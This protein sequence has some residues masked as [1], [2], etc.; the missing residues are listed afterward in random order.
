MGDVTELAVQV[1]LKADGTGLVGQLRLSQDAL[2]QLGATAQATGAQA[3]SLEA[4]TAA[5][6]A[7]A[8]AMAADLRQAQAAAGAMADE[9]RQVRTVAADLA[10]RVDVLESRLRQSNRT[11]VEGA[12]SAERHAFGIRNLGQQFGDLGLSIAGGISPARA[13]G[14]QAGQM[15]YAMSEMGGRAGKVGAFLTG[16]WGIALTVGAAVLA[17]LVE[18]LLKGGEAA[19]AMELGSSGLA[20]AQGALGDIFDLTTGKLKK[21]NSELAA[22]NELLRVNARLTAINLRTEAAQ[23][24][25][26]SRAA[27]AK[28]GTISTRG[29]LQGFG[30]GSARG[31]IAGLIG[32]VAG[33]EQGRFNA[34]NLNRVVADL[35]AGRT[36]PESV[37]RAAERLDFTGVGVDRDTFMAAIR[38][39]VSSAAK[40]EIADLTDQ[41]LNGGALPGGLR[42]EGRTKKPAKPASTAAR[43]EFGRDAADRLAAIT[44]Q[45]DATPEAVRKTNAEVRKLDDLIDD[46]RRKK[47]PNFAELIASAE[48]AKTVVR[49]GLIDGIAAAFDRPRTLADQAAAAFAE[50]DAVAADLERRR[51]PDL[52]RLL[53]QVDQ[54]RDRVRDGL[55][56]P[57]AEYVEAQAQSLQIGQALAAGDADRADALRAIFQLQRQM[58]PLTDEQRAAVLATTQALS[59]QERVV[60]RLARRQQNYL[61]ALGDMRSLLV[62]TIYEGPDAIAQLPKRLIDVFRRFAA[63]RLVEEWF[64]EA[65][66]ALRDQA[67]GRKPVEEAAE[68]MADAVDL[69]SAQTSQTNAALAELQTA[70]SGAARAVAGRGADTPA[71]GG[72]VADAVEEIV[73]RGKRLPAR[74]TDPVGDAIGKVLGQLGRRVGIDDA[75]AERIGEFVGKKASIGIKGA[76]EGQAAAS[77]AGMFGIKTSSTGASIGGALGGLTGL[78]GGSIVGGLLGGVVGNLFGGKPKEYGSSTIT[79]DGS[80]ASAGAAIG[81]GRAERETAGALGGSVADGL[82]RIAEALGADLGSASVSI[83]YRPGHKAGAYRVDTTGAGRVTGVEAFESEAEAIAFAIRDAIADGAVKTSAAVAKALQSSTDVDKAV[84]EAVK[85][86]ELETLLGGVSGQLGAAFRDM[87]RVAAE[88]VRLAKQY[89]LDLL[90]VEK[91]NAEQRADLLADTLQARVGSLK[92]LLANLTYG[93][94]F[95]GSAEDRRKSIL[96]EIADAQTDA[97]SGVEGAAARVGE[98]YRQLVTT[99]KEAFGTAGPEYT[100]D[101]DASRAG[102]ERVIQL[103]TDRVNAA[104]AGQ[105]ATTAAVQQGNALIDEGNDMLAQAVQLLGTIAVQGGGSGAGLMPDLRLVT[106]GVMP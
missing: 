2:T 29:R 92:D 19:K 65:F 3:R 62:Q 86:R 40:R 18:E 74:P 106:R 10:G 101:R 79:I 89:G 52:A 5:A 37:L 70:A 100:A 97:E 16:P 78:P 67:T 50:L 80:A 4:G 24:A 59:A 88:R 81:K 15:G 47:P 58:G 53:T 48:E 82:N 72:E 61:A 54:A 31:P 102:I 105:A 35:D 13:F 14:Q 28:A 71:A 66:D 27:L 90:Q 42:Q 36:R 6:G 68:R 93:D 17:P 49:R 57:L 64:G 8:E 85:V 84:A 1:R 9:L 96:Q 44:D 104:A 91:I 73:V 99:S 63:E 56:R 87:D 77:V 83:G 32:A 103:E 41:A 22:S 46:L 95:E 7:S 69:V 39:R 60:E 55:G 20:D 11:H 75:K 12:R 26:S 94:L 76:V 30:E 38:D 45:F 51:P 21:Q 34:A 25:Q 23:E 98:L 43:D 33:S